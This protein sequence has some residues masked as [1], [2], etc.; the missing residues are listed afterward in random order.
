MQ[1]QLYVVWVCCVVAF[2]AWPAILLTIRFARPRWMPWYVLMFCVGVIGWA[3]WGILIGSRNAY[4]DS[5]VMDPV[6]A[7]R[8]D[9]LV[10]EWEGDGGRNTFA[11]CFG[12]AISTVYFSPWYGIYMVACMVRN[13][14]RRGR[15]AAPTVTRDE[16]A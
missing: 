14:R 10:R 5:V 4:L 16:A 9:P 7:D 8:A 15:A 1:N 6:N 12:W 2:L 11:A 3:L 13:I